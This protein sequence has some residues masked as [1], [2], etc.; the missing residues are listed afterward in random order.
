MFDVFRMPK[1]RGSLRTGSGGRGPPSNGGSSSS[2][3]ELPR[4]STDDLDLAG[5]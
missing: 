1:R 2:S 4:K 3:L 5:R